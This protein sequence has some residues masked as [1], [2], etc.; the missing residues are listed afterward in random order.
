MDQ[1]AATVL[2]LTVLH[3]TVLHL[4][5]R[6]V[7][8]RHLTVPLHVKRPTGRRAATIPQAAMVLRAAH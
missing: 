3:L 8:V 4:T 1:L 7:T 2:H 6:L 5:V